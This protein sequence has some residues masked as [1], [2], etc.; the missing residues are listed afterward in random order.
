M[1]RNRERREQMR[2]NNGDSRP[3]ASG[4]AIIVVVEGGH[5]RR[6][7]RCLSFRERERLLGFS[8]RDSRFRARKMKTEP[9]SDHFVFAR[10]NSTISSDPDE[11]KMI[12]MAT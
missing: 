4:C 3:A 6:A 12:R 8:G 1:A 2:E 5:D 9:N 7:W 11:N 10:P